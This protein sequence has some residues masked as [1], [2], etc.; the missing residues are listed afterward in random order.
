MQSSNLFLPPVRASRRDLRGRHQISN[1]FLQELVVVVQLVVLMLDS[2]NTVE[3]LEERI[4]EDF[5]VPGDKGGCVSQAG[6]LK[7]MTESGYLGREAR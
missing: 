4:L 7:K 2:L 1:I 6:L 3:D 5:C